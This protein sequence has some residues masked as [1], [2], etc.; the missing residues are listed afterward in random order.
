MATPQENEA[1]SDLTAMAEQAQIALE[2]R[3][4][5]SIRARLTLGAVAWVVLTVGL[6]SASV[7]SGLADLRNH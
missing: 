7:A 6:A 2:Q 3:P 4:R 1:L 5:V